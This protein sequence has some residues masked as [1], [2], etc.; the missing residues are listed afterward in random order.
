MLIRIQFSKTGPVKFIGHLDTMRYFQKVLFKSGL[1]VRYTEGF[2]PHPI[3][4]FAN[5]L[6]VGISGNGEYL[7]FELEKELDP[8]FIEKSI[9][10]ALTPGFALNRLTVLEDRVPGVKKA[11]AMSLVDMA[12]HCIYMDEIPAGA[13][14]EGITADKIKSAFTDYLSA[15]H[16]E[17]SVSTKKSE[18]TFDLKEH[19]F[20]SGTSFEDFIKS[21]SIPAEYAAEEKSSI[22]ERPG[23]V[24]LYLRLS[25]GSAMNIRPEVVLEDLVKRTGLTVN[26]SDFALHRIEMF[27]I[28]DIG[29]VPLWAVK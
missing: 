24:Y 18:R 5:P 8:G 14:A 20:A 19:L 25:S 4:E 17:I 21:G 28:T 15:D 27:H 11:S 7:D 1:P 2:N 6:G 23:G 9:N 13:A 26:V 22:V 12:D 10:N 29:A 16:L 3:L